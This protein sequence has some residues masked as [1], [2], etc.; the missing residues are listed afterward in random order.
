[1][2]VGA[3]HGGAHRA[4]VPALLQLSRVYEWQASYD[5]LAGQI[6]ADIY[7]DGRRRGMDAVLRE[8]FAGFIMLTHDFANREESLVRNYDQAL[9]A[10]GRTPEKGS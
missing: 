10:L 1:V 3:R 6:L 5:A 7:M 9:A 8:G 2:D 4:A